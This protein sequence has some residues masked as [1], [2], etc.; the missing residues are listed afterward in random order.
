[1]KSRKRT[2][3]A[4]APAP[5]SAGGGADLNYIAEPLRPLAVEVAAVVADPRNARRHDRRNLDAIKASLAA[6]GQLKPIVLDAEGVVLAGNGT[7]AAARELGWTHVAAVKTPLRG[8][9]ARAFAIRDNRTAELAT[10]DADELAAQL[11]EI[12]AA[13]EG[14]TSEDM[15]FLE[16][17]LDALLKGLGENEERGT[18][19][20]ERGKDRTSEHPNHRTAE[21]REQWKIVIDCEDE[22]HQ[23]ELLERLTGDGLKC[24][25]LCG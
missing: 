2:R 1:M 8:V 24:R 6:S 18:L 12:S 13:G 23:V 17:E 7:C 22:G 25:A 19:N 14:I 10:W 5:S 21:L 20:A 11:E 16:S 3:A 9:A 4:P 15:G